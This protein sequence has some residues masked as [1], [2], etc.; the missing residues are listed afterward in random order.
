M[1]AAISPRGESLET[2]RDFG[3]P[4]GHLPAE[5]RR[6]RAGR[7]A[8]ARQ[9][10]P[11]PALL[12]RRGLQPCALRAELIAA[13]RVFRSS[14]DTEVVMEA[15]LAWGEAALLALPGRV[16]PG[17]R[18]P[19]GGSAVPGARPGRDQAPLL[20]PRRGAPPPRLRGQGPRRAGGSDR[21]GATRALRMG[22]PSRDPPARPLPRPA[23]A[24]SEGEPVEDLDHATEL[25]ASTL[26][27]AIA[28]RVDT[29]LPVAVI[30]SGGLDSSIVAT[31]VARLHPDCVAVTVGSPG[32]RGPRVC[33]ATD[34]R[35]RHRARGRGAQ[36]PAHRLSRG[37]RGRSGRRRP[38]STATPSTP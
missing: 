35:A 29:D 8:L 7:P 26:S 9:L 5:D 13:G 18:R 2:A 28:R 19:R 20:R 1:A 4:A 32:Q 25:V 36:P 23:R 33:E 31:E 21:R 38:R 12:Q 30:L 14:A 11:L 24:R 10:G 17:P 37:P 6:P 34:W 16:R 15:L 3:R 27:D 22:P